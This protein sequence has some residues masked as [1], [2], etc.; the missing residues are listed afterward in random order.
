[1]K[2]QQKQNTKPARRFKP[3]TWLCIYAI[4]LG[5]EFMC[6][7]VDYVGFIDNIT[8]LPVVGGMAAVVFV[9]LG[10][11]K[12]LAGRDQG[13]TQRMANA[14]ITIVCGVV[15]LGM[16]MMFKPMMMIFL[17]TVA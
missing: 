16:F 2:T 8:V 17:G 13:D 9:L 10:F 15:M 7:A 6:R 1:M 3:I 12:L 4:G 5:F 14:K 11:F